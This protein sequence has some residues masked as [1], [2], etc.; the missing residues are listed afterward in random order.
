MSADQLYES[1]A[2]AAADPKQPSG[3]GP[4]SGAFSDAAA[5]AISDEA[6]VGRERDKADWIRQF[7]IAYRTD[8]CDECSLFVGSIPQTLAMMNG[9]MTAEATD[10]DTSGLLKRVATSPVSEAKKIQQ[11]FLAALARNPTPSEQTAARKLISARGRDTAAGLEDLWWAL[12]NSNEFIL[13]R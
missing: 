2:A 9:E 1:L 11:L 13:D 6:F 8:E 10:A 3:D 5:N 12:L 4:A 7:V